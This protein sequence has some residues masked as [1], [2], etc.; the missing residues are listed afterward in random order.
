MKKS[1]SI[2]LI[3]L[4]AL[5]SFGFYLV[6]GYLYLNCKIESGIAIDNMEKENKEKLA[7]F[8]LDKNSE[9]GWLNK[10][11]M[12]INNHHYDVV[13]KE[14][15]SDKIYIYCLKDEKEDKVS[16]EFC[17]FNNIY[18]SNSPHSKNIS[19]LLFDKLIKNFLSPQLNYFGFRS[20]SYN[21]S[22]LDKTNYPV[23]FKNVISPPP[24]LHII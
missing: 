21:S 18:E 13:K 10:D 23:P 4:I 5:N 15:K 24:E 8:I 7:L 12:I 14:T 17:S 20:L 16:N 9:A 3:F 1:L 19:D 2:L 6:F 11:E 22:S